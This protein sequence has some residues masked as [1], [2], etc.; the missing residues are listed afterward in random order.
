[1]ARRHPN[2][3]PNKRRE[4]DVDVEKEIQRFKDELNKKEN[5]LQLIKVQ[6]VCRTIPKSRS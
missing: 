1:M 3:D 5:E 6:K 4:R 2:Y